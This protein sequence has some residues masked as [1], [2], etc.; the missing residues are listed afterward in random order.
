MVDGHGVV[1]V[2]QLRL[3]GKLIRHLV[4]VE[5]G[6]E[7]V[8]KFEVVVDEGW[9]GKIFKT[10]R[11]LLKLNLLEVNGWVDFSADFLN[12]YRRP[13]V[14]A[15]LLG[16]GKDD[17]LDQ[18]TRICE[19]KLLGDPIRHKLHIAQLA[20]TQGTRGTEG[21][22]LLNT[23]VVV[24]AK[25]EVGIISGYLD[26]ARSN[27]LLKCPK[28]ILVNVIGVET[29]INAHFSS[30]SQNLNLERLCRAQDELKVLLFGRF[31]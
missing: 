16:N 18:F 2:S 25:V 14:L 19:L 3:G 20:K 7:V 26:K 17:V 1:G 5:H 27:T 10:A 9:V 15:R 13:R 29:D 11:S 23:H 24:G 12:L 31:T 21:I 22:K 6:R 4:L 8:A 28:W 30:S